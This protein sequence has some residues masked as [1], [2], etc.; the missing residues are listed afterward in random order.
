[1][2]EPILCVIIIPVFAKKRAFPN[3]YPG[4]AF[5]PKK[6]APDAEKHEESE[7]QANVTKLLYNTKILQTTKFANL[8]DV[9]FLNVQ[10][11]VEII[12]SCWGEGG[13]AESYRK[14]A[15]CSRKLRKR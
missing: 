13:F 12:Q 10:K 5:R 8:P 15:E 4:H 2:A 14:V 1:M 9:K 11:L 7:N 6:N 3:F